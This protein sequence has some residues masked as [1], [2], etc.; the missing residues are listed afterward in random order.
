M[1]K[2]WAV[3][4]ELK[5][6]EEQEEPET[7][8]GQVAPLAHYPK[9]ATGERALSTA[10]AVAVVATSAVAVEG[11]IP[12]PVAVTLE[13]VEEVLPTP[14]PH[15]CRKRFTSRESGVALAC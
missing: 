10:E 15:W 9:G 7:V 1:V 13:A 4:V 8:P 5:L 6:P 2:P 12:M 3:A 11:R 14:I